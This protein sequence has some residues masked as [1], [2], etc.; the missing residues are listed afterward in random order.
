MI[1][2]RIFNVIARNTLEVLPDI[3]PEA[4]STLKSLAELGAN[5][6]DRMEIITLSMA[7]LGVTIPLVS[8]ATVS[9]IEGLVD[10]LSQYVQ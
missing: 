7:E 3:Q 4:I 2:E 5:S 6:V 1:R 10:T 9:N 8:F